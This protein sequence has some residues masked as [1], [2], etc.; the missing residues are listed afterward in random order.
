MMKKLPLWKLKRELKRALRQI[1]SLPELT[2]EYLVLRPLYDRKFA[3]MKVVYDGLKP[4]TGE[5]AIYLV[6]APTGLLNSH[7][8]FL[9]LLAVDG[10]TPVV[11]SNLPLSTG[12][13]DQLLA[14]SAMVIERPNIG[15]DFGGYRDAILQLAPDLHKLERLYILNDS[16]WMVDAPQSWFEQARTAECDYVGATSHYGLKR[17]NANECKELSWEYTPTDPNFHYASYALAIG[18]NILQDPEFIEY[19]RKLRLSNDKKRTVRRGEVGLTRWVR[20]H[21]YSHCATCDV[22]GFDQEIAALDDMTLDLVARN[23]VILE[24]LQLIGFLDEVLQSDPKTSQGRR[25]RIQIILMAVVRQAMGYAMPYFT[26]HYRDFQFVKKSPLR[27][28]R[29]GAET[30]LHILS[31]LEGQMAQHAHSEAQEIFAQRSED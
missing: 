16:V 18:P 2:W 23:L 26:L 8:D 11:V 14:Q 1:V 30:T 28:S 7:R 6:Y 21:G 31:Q 25:V 22:G 20:D 24:D 17:F 29:R 12:D 9:S 15:Y 3:R 19:W 5:I 13:R 4:I 27:L 10:I